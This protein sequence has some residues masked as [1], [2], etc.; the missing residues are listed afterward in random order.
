MVANSEPTR[1][2]ISK[3]LR[4]EILRRD[5]HACRYCGGVAPDVKL[6]VDHVLPIALGG[7]DDASNLVAACAD[8]N[9]GKSSS[10]PDQ[11]IIAQVS[12]DARRWANAVKASAMVIEQEHE[13][14]HDY[15]SE[16]TDLW[17][18]YDYGH[19][20][21][22]SIP[23]DD[24]WRNAIETFY[25]RGLPIN[26]LLSSAQ[27]ALENQRIGANAAF[28]YFMGIAWNRLTDIEALAKQ[29]YDIQMSTSDE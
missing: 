1:K 11:Q 24:N 21:E 14:I 20:R 12:E 8:C 2:P 27:I 7:T 23:M 9:A 18:S 5:N 4:F 16:F 29:V 13:A 17:A 6:T 15:V 22:Y 26:V 28:R 10:N 19:N 25:K 3:R